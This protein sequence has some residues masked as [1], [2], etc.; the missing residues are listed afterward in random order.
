LKFAFDT[1]TRH[2]INAVEG[3][4]GVIQGRFGGA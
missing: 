2:D 3:A 1:S 4:Q